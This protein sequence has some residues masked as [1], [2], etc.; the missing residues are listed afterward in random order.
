MASEKEPLDDESGS[1]Y[2][3]DLKGSTS[4]KT[5]GGGSTQSSDSHSTQA[6]WWT[7]RTKHGQPS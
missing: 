2:A 4:G 5:Y 1:A 6:G 7:A 3:K